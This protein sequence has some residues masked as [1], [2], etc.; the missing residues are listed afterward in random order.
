MLSCTIPAD[1]D[2]NANVECYSCSGVSTVFPSSQPTYDWERS[3]YYYSDYNYYNYY[4][5]YYNYNRNND[6]STDD[7]AADESEPSCVA[8]SCYS[9]QCFSCEC[10]GPTAAPTI[11][12]SPPPTLVL[13]SGAELRDALEGGGDNV[14]VGLRAEETIELDAAL[15]VEAGRS[16][17]I[18]SAA[19]SALLGEEGTTLT[20][21]PT[22]GYY[23]GLFRLFEVYE[24]AALTLQQLTLSSARYF[25]PT[26][27]PETGGGAVYVDSG[28]LTL[29]SAT[30]S[31]NS[32][33]CVEPA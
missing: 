27:Y 22:L 8:T 25:V 20:P 33:P 29:L 5:Y 18:Y 26:G 21:D 12:P 1:A 2:S 31:G 15:A 7:D 23:D 30:L 32:S 13:T 19:E 9:C 10:P 14:A 3:F 24:G 28:S 11:T 17:S 4:N 16:V 6:G